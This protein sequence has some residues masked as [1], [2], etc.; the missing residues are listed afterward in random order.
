VTRLLCTGDLHLGAGAAVAP[1]PGERLAEQAAVWA[2][3]VWIAAE[4][5]CDAILFAG[6]AFERPRPTPAEMLAFGQPLGT[7]PVY[8]IPGNHDVI[9]A[10]APNALEVFQLGHGAPLLEH[11]R[12]PGIF[13]VA[14]VAVATLPWAPVSRLVA[15]HG[16][17][18]RTAINDQAATLL[19]E[20]ARGLR[21]QISAGVPAI[22]MLHWSVSGAVTPTGADVGIFAEPVLDLG[23]LEALG[24]DAILMGHI[25]AAQPLGTLAPDD[26]LMPIFYVGSPLPLN[27]GEASC[28]HGVWLLDIDEAIR[29]RR[30][31]ADFIPIE[32]RRFVTIDFDCTDETQLR[33]LETAQAHPSMIAPERVADAIVKVRYRASAEQA[34]RID[35]AKL[36][37][38]LYDAGAHHVYA[39]QPEI[40]REQRA[41]VAELD[42]SIDELS[43]LDLYMDANG[44]NGDRASAL[45]ERTSDYLK[46]V[47]S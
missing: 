21:A 33:W 32:S 29:P 43:A 41:R 38:A 24:F 39:I 44:V 5:E 18:E 22:L 45:R 4:H 37:A 40:V 42:D 15:A 26:E 12:K 6:D 34:R 7:V 28:D 3:I 10:D 36:K 27:F 35:H 23:D 9:S 19:V 17:G 8:A 16:G 31:H 2:Q 20:T 46:E 47:A 11:D 14:G 30:V 1:H 25:H 13:G